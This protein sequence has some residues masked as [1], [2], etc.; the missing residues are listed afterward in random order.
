VWVIAHRG[1]SHLRPENTLEAFSNATAVGADVLEMDVRSTADGALVVIHDATVDRTT[2]GSGAVET[3]TL[4]DLQKQDAAFRWSADGGKTFPFRSKG[5]RVPTLESVFA[6]F[7]A[8]RMNLEIKHPPGSA[9]ARPLCEQIRAHRMAERV[10]VASMSDEAIGAFRSACPE[11]ATSLAASEARTFV[12]A[13]YAWLAA[14]YTP[15][16]VALQ[17]PDRLRDR[18][19]A[20]PGLVEAAHRRNLKVHAWT[21]NDEARMRELV[22]IGIDGIITDR[23]DALARILGRGR[24]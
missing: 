18:I 5:V 15:R 21:V 8:T 20:T 24:L 4:G 10:L 7:P 16:G 6:R 19:L 1:G 13:S 9:I 22:A 23:P 11:V 14:A 12:Y 17:V 2:D 3:M